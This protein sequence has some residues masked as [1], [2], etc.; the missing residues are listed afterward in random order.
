MTDTTVDGSATGRA[1]GAGLGTRDKRGDWRP[2]YLIEPP[3]PMAWPPKPLGVVKWL[4]GFPGYLWP[5]NAA[6]LGIAAVAWF[7][8]TPPL[9]AMQSFEIGWIAAVW[10]R[11]LGLTVLVFGGFHLYFY[12]LKGQGTDFKFTTR[13]LARDNKHFTFGNQV[14]DNMFWTLASGVTIWTAY[15]VVTLWLYAN[16]LIPFINW[17]TD[18]VW[19]VALLLLIPIF[20]EFHFYVVHRLIH[21]KPL[22]DLAHALHHRNVNIGPWSGLSMHPIEHILYFSGVLVHWVV[23][24]HPLHAIFHLLHTGISPA[25]GHCG[26]DRIALGGGRELKIDNYYHYLHHKNFECNYSGDGFPLFDRLFG[27]Y[28][29]GS[30]EAQ[31]RMN[32][33]LAA[34]RWAVQPGGD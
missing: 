7:F 5:W 33:R 20:R 2:P 32:R 4:L 13:P 1:G 34:R 29:D 8:L 27:T 18:P 30:D 26:F 16:G 10:A 25:Q 31:E 19:F 3:A 22:Y 9:A 12:I 23:A 11:N 28:H 15:E 21:W 14:H 6:F 17:E 24:S